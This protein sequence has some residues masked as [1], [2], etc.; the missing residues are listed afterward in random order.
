MVEIAK[1][2]N[3]TNT[4]KL[5]HLSVLAWEDRSKNKYNSVIVVDC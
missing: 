5:K 3:G 1:G 4:K 2:E